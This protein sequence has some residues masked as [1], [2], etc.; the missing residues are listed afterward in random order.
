MATG[1]HHA[2]PKPLFDVKGG[3]WYFGFDCPK[4][5]QRFAVFDDPS[6]GTIEFDGATGIQVACSHCNDNRL[7]G[8]GEVRNFEAT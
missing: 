5:G 7:Y 6:K 3:E 1:V 8:I 4:C 2:Q